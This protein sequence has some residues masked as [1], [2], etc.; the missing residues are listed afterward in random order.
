[1]LVFPVMAIYVLSV[2]YLMF[3]K[4]VITLEPRKLDRNAD[5]EDLADIPYSATEMSFVNSSVI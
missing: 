5:R 2:L 3:R 4:D 1:M